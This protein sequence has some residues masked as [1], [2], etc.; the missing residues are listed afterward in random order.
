M[1]NCEDEV[2]NFEVQSKSRSSKQPSVVPVG[3]KVRLRDMP[4]GDDEDL[5]DSY[6]RKGEIGNRSGKPIMKS[7]RKAGSKL[8]DGKI[9]SPKGTLNKVKKFPVT[10][11]DSLSSISSLGLSYSGTNQEIARLSHD[12][13][14]LQAS[15]LQLKADNSKLKRKIK[16]LVAEKVDVGVAFLQKESQYKIRVQVQEAQTRMLNQV[17]CMT[18]P[19]FKC[20]E[21]DEISPFKQ[22]KGQNSA[23]D[24]S[25]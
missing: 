7:G 23:E 11:P 13:E 22:Q 16:T 2:R 18:T 17:V 3:P 5:I 15:V 6:R 19:N 25:D 14:S 20:T 4:R 12:N 10:S 21:Y 9:V 8:V 1:F 24:D